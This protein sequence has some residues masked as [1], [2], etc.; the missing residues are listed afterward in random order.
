M[1][2]YHLNNTA[3]LTYFDIAFIHPEETLDAVKKIVVNEYSLSFVLTVVALLERLYRKQPALGIGRLHE[4]F[5]QTANNDLVVFAGLTFL[6]LADIR[7][8]CK[9]AR[10]GNA[11]RFF[12]P[13]LWE[14][15]R[16][17]QRGKLQELTGETIYTWAVATLA[18]PEK[19]PTQVQY[20]VWFHDLYRKCAS[21]R[22]N[23]LE[24]YLDRWQIR[25]EAKVAKLNFARKPATPPITAQDFSRLRPQT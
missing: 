10:R 4:W 7:D 2:Q 22:Q 6:E 20:I 14:G 19:D 11:V 15:P 18:M 1:R 23:R 25:N 9:Q 24:F 21:A 5:T 3:L 17:P 12:F 8:F 16:V 13:V